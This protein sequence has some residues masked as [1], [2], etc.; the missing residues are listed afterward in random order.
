MISK[1]NF[2]INKHLE[3]NNNL[4]K[5]YI[6]FFFIKNY[7]KNLNYLNNKLFLKKLNIFKKKYLLKNFCIK[8]NNTYKKKF[9]NL[10]KI[11]KNNYYI[12]YKFFLNIKV[13]INIKPILFIIYYNYFFF[14]FFKKKKKFYK[15]YLFIKK[16]YSYFYKFKAFYFIFDCKYYANKKIPTTFFWSFDYNKNNWKQFKLHDI[17]LKFK[18]IVFKKEIKLI[19]MSFP[20]Y[21]I[22]LK[23][24]FKKNL[25]KIKI[26]KYKYVNTRNN[27]WLNYKNTS[28]NELEKEK[29]MFKELKIK[30]NIG[31][32]K[33]LDNYDNDNTKFNNLIERS[34]FNYY[35]SFK[36]N[37]F[38]NKIKFN[39]PD[40]LILNK[41]EKNLYRNIYFNYLIS[42]KYR[43]YFSI[44][45]KKFKFIRKKNYLPK[46]SKFYIFKKLKGIFFFLNI[47]TLKLINLNSIKYFL[48][49][50]K[51]LKL[52]KK[53]RNMFSFLYFKKK[54][55]KTFFFRK[56][57]KIFFKKKIFFSKKKF[58]IFF[59]KKNIFY[60][61][62]K[63]KHMKVFIK[64]IDFRKYYVNIQSI[65]CGFL[66]FFKVVFLFLEYNFFK[67]IKYFFQI[68]CDEFLN[69]A[70]FRNNNFWKWI[71]VYCNGFRGLNKFKKYERTLINFKKIKLTNFILPI[72][73][74]TK[75][76]KIL[77]EL[78]K[79]MRIYK[80]SFK[81]NFFFYKFLMN[82]FYKNFC[83]YWIRIRIKNILKKLKKRIWLIKR[84]FKLRQIRPSFRLEFI[85]V[86][87]VTFLIK[88]PYILL[89]WIYRVISIIKFKDHWNFLF[90]IKR[91]IILIAN[92]FM[93]LT[94]FKGI[95]IIVKGKIGSKGSVRKKI[96]HIKTGQVS[97]SNFLLKG[98]NLYSH[99]NTDT[100]KIG[101][102]IILGYN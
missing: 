29:E 85:T 2:K 39:K 92:S 73:F 95:H 32:L 61:K 75:N 66:P 56:H 14:N 17:E 65:I 6:I 12:I 1:Y 13:N 30:F 52:K 67:S 38:K 80:Y 58:K 28:L 24:K 84:I 94:K 18:S 102:K 34:A 83:L 19:N 51:M 63:K 79:K 33:K 54:L 98:D 49:Y 37:N 77:I 87:S 72:Y 15:F 55:K 27:Y 44:I 40:L 91:G 69:L 7:F 47:R 5:I 68:L 53:Y 48:I 96:F 25:K 23:K 89:N 35:N 88:D 64:N 22:F 60:F 99:S 59:L 86:V 31:N 42:K 62:K 16:K 21:F 26:K 50:V 11:K 57:F 78:N 8:Q 100:G 82:V 9:L 71:K 81:F 76:L 41:F 20:T 46:C 70:L 93:L 45:K 90:N 101:I 10:K 74:P 4:S 43:L 97:A 36:K 3:N